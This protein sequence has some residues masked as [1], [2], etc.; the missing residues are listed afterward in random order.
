MDWKDIEQR[1]CDR[2]EDVCRHLLPQGKRNGAEWCV[3]S[4]EGEKGD[5][6][7]INLSGKVGVWADFADSDKKGKTLMSLWCHRRGQPFAACFQ[8][9]KEWLGIRDEWRERRVQRAAAKSSPDGAEQSGSWS[10]WRVKNVKE[11]WGKCQPLTED[12]PVWNYLVNGRG[13]EPTVLEAY[14]V[15]EV[16]VSGLFEKGGGWAMVFP[17]YAPHAREEQ[18][19]IEQAI[20][21]ASAG[22]PTGTR[23]GACAPRIPTWLKFE[24]LERREGKKQE[25]TTPGPEKCLWGMQL[26]EHPMF[27]RADHLL[28]NEGEKDP[29][30]WATY[31]CAQWRIAGSGGV[32]PVSVPFG[33]KWRPSPM[34]TANGFL[35][36]RPSPNREWLDRCWDWMQGFETIFV[37]MDMD[38]E[39]RKA[40]VDIITEIGPRRCRLVELPE[41]ISTTD[42]HG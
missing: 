36:Q 26:L 13:L 24:H 30:S 28:I 23:E 40:A 4:V 37:G 3:G 39:G 21:E 9:A 12:G 19:A 1:L 33:A 35:E 14:E 8:E 11:A 27:R 38:E 22:A 20:A 42:G 25:W 15:R 10:R 6:L 41:K 32:L 34:K 17:Y 7:R 2:V 5:S 18:S 31:G 16:L 29:L